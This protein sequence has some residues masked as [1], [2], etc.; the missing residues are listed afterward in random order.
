[1]RNAQTKKTAPRK[2][3]T[4]AEAKGRAMVAD[5]EQL[6]AIMKAGIPVE[7]KYTVRTIDLPD[8]PGVYGAAAVRAM[9]Q[10]RAAKPFS[11]I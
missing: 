2:P 1:M 7:S 3:Y 9:Q 6:I 11:P 5:L 8:G 4:S 10:N